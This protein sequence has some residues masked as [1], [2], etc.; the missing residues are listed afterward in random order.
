MESQIAIDCPLSVSL[1]SSRTSGEI[2][3]RHR[4]GRHAAPLVERQR[5]P[6]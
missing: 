5:L 6:L 1:I 2:L 3:R 4:G